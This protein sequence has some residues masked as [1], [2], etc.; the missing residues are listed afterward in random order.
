MGTISHGLLRWKI[1]TQMMFEN[2]Y[3]V[4][5]LIFPHIQIQGTKGPQDQDG[6]TEILKV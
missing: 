2:D 3:K 6:I 1:E 4:G 5:D